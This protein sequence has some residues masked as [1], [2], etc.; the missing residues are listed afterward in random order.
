MTPSSEPI[1]IR[2]ARP[3]ILNFDDFSP[4]FSQPGMV[5]EGWRERISER[6]KRRK[7][8]TRHAD[9]AAFPPTARVV[10]FEEPD[11]SSP[12]SPSCGSPS[13]KDSPVSRLF[14]EMNGLDDPSPTPLPPPRS[15]ATPCRPVRHAPSKPLNVLAPLVL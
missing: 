10:G 1:D 5:S 6:M 3:R 4:G 11:S 13:G 8:A 12:S 9:G 15:L 14:L 7:A 2:N